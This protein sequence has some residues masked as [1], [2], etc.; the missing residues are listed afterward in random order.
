VILIKGATPIPHKIV[1]IAS[2]AAD[3]N[4]AVLMAASI[5]T[6]GAR[7]FLVAALLRRYGEPMRGFIERRRTL[8]TTLA[9]LGV[10]GGF[11]ALKLL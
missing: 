3:F 6:R 9:V 1:T 2:G 5:A 11:L 8:V 7:F 4:F 10:A